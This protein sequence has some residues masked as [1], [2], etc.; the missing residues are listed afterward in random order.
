MRLIDFKP[1]P[2][3][4]KRFMARFVDP[5]NVIHFG[6]KNECTFIDHGDRDLRHYYFLSQQHLFQDDVLSGEVLNTAILW[7]PMPSIE[8]NLAW[9]LKRYHIMDCR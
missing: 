3:Q 2:I 6:M 1:S 7:G 8:G 9:F 4:T 5:P